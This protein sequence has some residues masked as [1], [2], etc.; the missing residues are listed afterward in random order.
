MQ[1]CLS[2]A[3]ALQ[4]GWPSLQIVKF[5]TSMQSVGV[6][7]LGIVA[8]RA[9]RVL[10]LVFEKDGF[11]EDAT[12]VLGKICSFRCGSSRALC[13]S[14]APLKFRTLGSAA[15]AWPR[16]SQAADATRHCRGACTDVA[17]TWRRCRTG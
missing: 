1:G 14:D 3:D 8:R 13:L 17:H 9:T 6:N 15:Q 5:S 12:S 2:G 4:V 7:V 10:A 16:S 11:S